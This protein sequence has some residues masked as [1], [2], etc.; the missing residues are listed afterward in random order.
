MRRWMMRGVTLWVIGPVAAAASGDVVYADFDTFG[1]D[2]TTLT[3]T[4]DGNP[5]TLEILNSV[6]P[7]TNFVARGGSSRFDDAS[8][9]FADGAIFDP[10][11]SGTDLLGMV[12]FSAGTDPLGSAVA[13][14]TFDAPVQDLHVHITG[15]DRAG[16]DFEQTVSAVS[17]RGGTAEF[18]VSGTKVYDVD[19]ATTGERGSVLV[20]G[21]FDV[22]EIELYEVVNLDDGFQLQ[23]ST[24]GAPPAPVPVPL[25]GPL[26]LAALA[27]GLA[28]AGV[29]AHREPEPG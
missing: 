23:F 15:L 19:P 1:G 24:P 11:K 4:L 27:L 9:A 3:G 2:V 28:G 18:T 12:M 20:P 14:I 10:P 8:T 16:L 29:A 22:F 21:T 17:R 26:G 25:L 6:S 13:R 5:F 7:P